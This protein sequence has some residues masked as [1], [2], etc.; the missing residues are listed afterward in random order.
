M[1]RAVSRI[2]SPAVATDIIGIEQADVFV[3]LKPRSES[4]VLTLRGNS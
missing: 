4:G 3:G 2:G 1:T